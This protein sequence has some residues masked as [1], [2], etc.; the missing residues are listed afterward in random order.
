MIKL[1]LAV[2]TTIM[3][4]VFAISNSHHVGLSC[5]VGKPLEVRLIFLL[6]SAFLIGML[7]PVFYR[8]IRRLDSE[9][10]L[11]RENEL[12]QAVER[13]NGGILD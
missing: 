4:V 6:L 5:A 1:T 12:R 13:A 2:L 8:L 9:R 3:I 7:V 11:R 10:Q